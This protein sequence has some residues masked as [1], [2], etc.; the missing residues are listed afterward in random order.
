MSTYVRFFYLNFL[1]LSISVYER[2]LIN[3]I[4]TQQLV[5][6]VVGDL[7]YVESHTTGVHNGGKSVVVRVYAPKGEERHGQ[8]ALKIA[9]ETLEYFAEGSEKIENDVIYQ[10][11]Y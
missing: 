6:F 2:I 5:A 11:S 4:F 7:G 10:N 8:F 9:T 1:P 3:C